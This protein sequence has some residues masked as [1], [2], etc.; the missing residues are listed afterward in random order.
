V[1]SRVTP[2]QCH[3]QTQLSTATE[4]ESARRPHCTTVQP[5]K[6]LAL[7]VQRSV[8][9]SAGRCRLHSSSGH[10]SPSTHRDISAFIDVQSAEYRTTH[11]D[12]REVWAAVAVSVCVLTA[13]MCRP[14]T[15]GLWCWPMVTTNLQPQEGTALR[16]MHAALRD[17]F[18]THTV[19]VIRTEIRPV[20]AFPFSTGIGHYYSR[21]FG[22]EKRPGIP[23]AR[24]P[25]V[26][27]L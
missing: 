8:A 22:N 23:G 16:I 20:V 25:A 17:P 14:V 5:S 6:R 3:F 4:F 10:V 7:P 15:N 1:L 12:R 24:F 21:E 13:V 26:M 27:V 19:C 2:V 9:P 11:S 18:V